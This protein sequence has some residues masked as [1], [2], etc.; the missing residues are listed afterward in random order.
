M[1]IRPATLED[2]PSLLAIAEES[3]SAAHWTRAQYETALVD[4][5]PKR[6]LLVLVNES[7]DIQGFI[8]AAEAAGEWELENIAIAASSRRRGGADQLVEALLAELRSSRA[9]CLHLEVRE[10]NTAARA[11]YEK[12]GFE[13]SG[14]RVRYYHTPPEDAILYRKNLSPAAPE[15]G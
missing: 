11:L 3:V 6:V 7:G 9:E 5:L 14:R 15:I 12:W 10:S 4:T 2:I 1:S 13:V 8:V